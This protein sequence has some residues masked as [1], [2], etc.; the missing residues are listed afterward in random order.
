MP[1]GPYAPFV[2]IAAMVVTLIVCAYFAYLDFPAK[3]EKQIAAQI[4][5]EDDDLCTK[6]GF[7]AG[8]KKATEC[9]TDLANLRLQHEKMIASREYW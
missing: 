9:G 2:P 8:T 5:R 4:Q 7:A 3:T 6:F 1:K